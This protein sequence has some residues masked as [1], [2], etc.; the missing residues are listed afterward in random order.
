MTYGR[1]QVL[2]IASAVLSLPLSYPATLGFDAR[3]NSGANL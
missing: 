3:I 1:A 2:M